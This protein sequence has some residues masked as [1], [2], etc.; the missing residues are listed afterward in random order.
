KFGNY[1]KLGK[2]SR[3]GFSVS[4]K[5]EYASSIHNQY[6]PLSGRLIFCQTNA[7]KLPTILWVEII[8]IARPQVFAAADAGTAPQHQLI[9]HEFA[10]VFTQCAGG[11]SVAWIE[12]IGATCPFT[13]GAKQLLR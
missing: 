11:R 2:F 10:I 12:C 9:A 7:G 4:I 13:E 3:Q 8:A 6:L 5:F 1:V